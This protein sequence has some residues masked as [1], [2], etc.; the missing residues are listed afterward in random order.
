MSEVSEA[1]RREFKHT[2]DIR[3]AGLTTPDYVLR[4]DDIVYGTTDPGMQI[5]DVYRPKDKEGEILPVIVS[6]HGGAWVYGDKERYQ[7]YCMSLV[8]HGFAVVNFTYRLAPEYKFPASLEDT[9]LVM[10]FVMEHAKEYGL[11]TEH[12]FAVGDSAGAHIL[13]LYAGI[14]TNADYA[15]KYSFRV[16]ENFKLCAIALNCGVY[17]VHPDDEGE[18]LDWKLMGEYLPE[19]GSVNEMELINVLHCITEDYPPTF[20]MI[21]TGDFLKKQTTALQQALLENEVPQEFLFYGK[22]G[23][24]FGHVFHL[25]MKLD[26][27]HRCNKAECDFFRSWME[28][29]Q[30]K[31]A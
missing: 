4:Y 21:C 6:V 23:T 17:E 13:G 5:L 18:S 7:Y 22:K 9:N 2:D 26:I 11:D 19:G 28:N 15:K 8:Q 1:I 30:D 12:I 10:R 27:A 14:C 20:Y 24:D 31:K 3:D 25:N 29:A 16:P